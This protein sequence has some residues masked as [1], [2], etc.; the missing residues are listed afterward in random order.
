MSP[1]LF[2]NL[3]HPFARRSILPLCQ[4]LF[5]SQRHFPLS[6]LFHSPPT[7]SGPAALPPATT[8][9]PLCCVFCTAAM[10]HGASGTTPEV[11]KQEACARSILSVNTCL[12]LTALIV[13]FCREKRQKHRRLMRCVCVCM[14]V[15]ATGAEDARG[16][17]G[18]CEASTE[19]IQ[20]LS[21]AHLVLI[22]C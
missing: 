20:C 16:K 5:L 14:C 8:P 1:S 15:C 21:R 10:S 18:A 2:P 7:F 11:R 19:K 6:L 4:Q 12:L 13:T 9:A 22:V 17:G 3:V